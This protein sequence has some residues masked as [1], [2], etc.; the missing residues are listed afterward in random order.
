MKLWQTV[1]VMWWKCDENTSENKLN[2]FLSFFQCYSYVKQ[3]VGKMIVGLCNCYL[4]HPPCSLCPPSTRNNHDFPRHTTCHCR[5]AHGPR[6]NQGNTKHTS[7]ICHTGEPER[8]PRWVQI[9]G[10][11]VWIRRDG[12]ELPCAVVVVVGVVVVVVGVVV[13]VVGECS[14]VWSKLEDFVPHNMLHPSPESW[15]HAQL[16]SRQKSDVW[17]CSDWNE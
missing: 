16:Q 2:K 17:R 14:V 6:N 13:V 7:V 1:T 4:H 5:S 15:L 9:N 8:K 11:I 3:G 12:A 10:F